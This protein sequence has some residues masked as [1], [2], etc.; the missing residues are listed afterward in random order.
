MDFRCSK[1]PSHRDCSF[2]Y[3]QNMSLLR[4]KQNNNYQ[5]QSPSPSIPQIRLQKIKYI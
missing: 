5:L 2:K 1:E 3:P 4:N